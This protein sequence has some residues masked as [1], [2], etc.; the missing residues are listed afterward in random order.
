M[1]FGTTVWNVGGGI[2]YRIARLLVLQMGIDVARGP[3]DWVFNIVSG[4][5]W[6]K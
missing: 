1:I 5:A 3:E 4:N 6:L 2:R